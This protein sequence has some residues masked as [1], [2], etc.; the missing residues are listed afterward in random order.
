[1]WLLCDTCRLYYSVKICIDGSIFY[2]MPFEC[3]KENID[4]VMFYSFLFI[5]ESLQYKAPGGSL[6][7]VSIT[8][9]GLKNVCIC[10]K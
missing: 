5:V 9:I 3:R 7:N 10:K 4:S 6:N 8:L 1:M 2:L